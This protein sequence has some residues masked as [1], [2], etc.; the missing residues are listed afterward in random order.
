MD[1]RRLSLNIQTNIKSIERG[2]IL[3]SRILFDN[4]LEPMTFNELITLNLL[5]VIGANIMIIIQLHL[6]FRMQLI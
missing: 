6:E 3:E 1:P 2:Q 4:L 5:N